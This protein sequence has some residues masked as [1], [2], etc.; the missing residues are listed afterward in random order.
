MLVK[1]AANGG[2][3]QLCILSSY[4]K[5]PE[6]NPA[7]DS[8]ESKLRQKWGDW[9][10]LTP[11]DQ[12]IARA[13]YSAVRQK[14]PEKLASVSDAVDH[15]DHIVQLAGIEHVGIGTDFDGGG[16]L[17]DCTDASQMG[18]IT[19]E[20]VKRG[21][22]KKDIAKIWSGNI[23]RVMNEVETFAAKQKK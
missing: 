22:S 2:V 7:R 13:E 9:S 12:K 8:A 23:F 11:E 10:K 1:L 19:L 15:I 20:L 18:N 6:P 5:N 14:Y 17:S 4:V 3:I 21:Y 16:G